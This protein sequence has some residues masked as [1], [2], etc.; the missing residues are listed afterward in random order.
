MPEWLKS[1]AMPRMP[2]AGPTPSE[3]L[4]SVVFLVIVAARRVIRHSHPGL[5]RLQT[6]SE[7][8]KSILSLIVAVGCVTRH[9]HSSA[10]GPHKLPELI[11]NSFNFSLPYQHNYWLPA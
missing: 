9:N 10:F 5:V 1:I 11:F 7:W 6:N 8:L 3:W 2:E 4:K